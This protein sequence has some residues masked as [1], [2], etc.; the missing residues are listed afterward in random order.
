MISCIR[1]SKVVLYRWTIFGNNPIIKWLFSYLTFLTTKNS[2]ITKIV[3]PLDSCLSWLTPG[4]IFKMLNSTFSFQLQCIKTAII[5][6][7]SKIQKITKIISKDLKSFIASLL[8][9]KLALVAVGGGRGHYVTFPYVRLN[10][11]CPLII[12]AQFLNQGN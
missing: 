8:R 9:A 5:I 12:V 6:C 10:F 4:K 3:Q 11:Q 7:N 1:G 2:N